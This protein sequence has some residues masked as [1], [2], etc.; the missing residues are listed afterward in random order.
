MV[1]FVI[2]YFGGFFVVFLTKQNSR[3]IKKIELTE[4]IFYF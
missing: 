1:Y 4:S 2:M 3:V